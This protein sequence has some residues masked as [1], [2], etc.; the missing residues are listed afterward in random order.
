M[1]CIT[2]FQTLSD[3]RLLKLVIIHRWS[4]PNRHFVFHIFLVLYVSYICSADDSLK[5]SDELYLVKFRQKH[6]NELLKYINIYEILFSTPLG[7]STHISVMF[8][9][10]ACQLWE[11]LFTQ[12]HFSVNSFTIKHHWHG[13]HILLACVKESDIYNL[14]KIDSNT[15]L[16]QTMFYLYFMGATSIW[17]LY[18]TRKTSGRHDLLE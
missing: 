14:N 6:R 12:I 17:F 5:T 2:G 1:I 3:H 10:P 13:C 9:L 4:L 8:N 18:T 11:M 16:I 15:F 7:A